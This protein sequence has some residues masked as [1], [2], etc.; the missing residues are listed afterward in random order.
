MRCKIVRF[1][2]LMWHSMMRLTKNQKVLVL[3]YRYE[4]NEYD[5]L[6]QTKMSFTLPLSVYIYVHLLVML[7]IIR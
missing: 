5:R 4:F 3:Q 1:Q 2:K 7:L 6:Y